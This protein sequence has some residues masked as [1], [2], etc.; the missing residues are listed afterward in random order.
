MAT[1]TL[2]GDLAYFYFEIAQA[3]DRGV[4]A[5]LDE[6]Y[7]A[8]ITEYT[9]ELVERY[10]EADLSLLD[11]ADREAIN[12]LYQEHAP[13]P[14]RLGIG[15]NGLAYLGGVVIPIIRLGDWHDPE[16]GSSIDVDSLEIDV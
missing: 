9:V 12:R 10:F 5:P 11:E 13:E 2:G 7:D 3:V 15:D 14:E 16:T 1:L 4:K 8:A 6:A